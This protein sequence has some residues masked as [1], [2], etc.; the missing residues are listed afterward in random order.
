[1]QT[2]LYTDS[3]QNY[4]CPSGAPSATPTPFGATA[5]LY[6]VTC[7]AA[8]TPDSTRLLPAAVL[9]NGDNCIT[10]RD[11]LFPAGPLAEHTGNHYFADNVTAVFNFHTVVDN[12]FIIAAKKT[13]NVTAVKDYT[14]VGNN[15]N[16]PVAW[17]QLQTLATPPPPFVEEKGTV[18]AA[19]Q[20]VYRVNVA[21]GAPPPTCADLPG[22]GVITVPYAAEYW[23]FAPAP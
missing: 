18:P 23:F 12:Y 6:N 16:N 11:T 19:P 4:T 22:G 17:L 3:M 1:M 14:S 9:E 8:L 21:G 2:I 15:N 13:A 20:Q 7:S 5:R 10:E